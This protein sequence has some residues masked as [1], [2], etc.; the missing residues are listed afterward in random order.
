MSKE[1][2]KRGT[3]RGVGVMS[4]MTREEGFSSSAYSNKRNR[5][6]HGKN[7]IGLDREYKNSTEFVP[8]DSRQPCGRCLLSRQCP[9]SALW[10]WLFASDGTPLCSHVDESGKGSNN[11]TFIR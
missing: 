4:Q 11:A 6:S 9:W 3:E 1:A 7:S 2:S 8:I 5:K 10:Y